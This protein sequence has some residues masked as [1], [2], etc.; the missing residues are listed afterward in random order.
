M[1]PFPPIRPSV[2][3]SHGG[4][5]H[6]LQTAMSSSSP[7]PLLAVDPLAVNVERHS[8]QKP[9]D[10]LFH[11][12]NDAA[13]VRRCRVPSSCS[14]FSDNVSIS[15][16]SF[17]SSYCSRGGRGRG[18]G[19]RDG[20]R[21][22]FGSRRRGPGKVTFIIALLAIQSPAVIVVV[23]VPGGFRRGRRRRRLNNS[24]REGEGMMLVVVVPPSGLKEGGRIEIPSFETHRAVG[25]YR[26]V[27]GVVRVVGDRLCYVKESVGRKIS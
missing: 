25:D 17:C 21:C 6:L 1:C 7:S 19:G 9:P 16:S 22:N 14:K 20:S 2:H 23:V 15:F 26:M 13:D 18:G 8:Q 24:R 4:S 10:P 11:G 27:S 5:M 12:T 3:P